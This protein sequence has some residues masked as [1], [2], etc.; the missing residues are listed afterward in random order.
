MICQQLKRVDQDKKQHKAPSPII[1]S[2]IWVIC[3]SNLHCTSRLALALAASL[4]PLSAE[5]QYFPD[6]SLLASKLS[7]SPVPTVFPSLI[8]VTLGVGFPVAEQWNVALED[9]KI[10]WL[11]GGLVILG[12]TAIKIW[13]YCQIW[14]EIP[15]NKSIYPVHWYKG[16]T[17]T[18]CP[19]FL[20]V[21][22][23]V[24]KI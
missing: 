9:S 2:H 19:I 10:V 3:G 22:Y 5:H 6:L 20:Y 14:Q 8:H 17:G 1:Y 16:S 21:I 4:K 7:L 24:V 12:A 18:V 23:V 15:N 11:A 13:K